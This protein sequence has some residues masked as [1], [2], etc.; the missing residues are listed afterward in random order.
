MIL[1]FRSAQALV[2]GI[3]L[4]VYKPERSVRYIFHQ[5]HEGVVHRRIYALVSFQRLFDVDNEGFADDLAYTERDNPAV[6]KY[7]RGVQAERFVNV[8]K[9]FR[10]FELDLFQ[11][12]LVG[13]LL[14]VLT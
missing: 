14:F 9:L 8:E 12:Q 2:S 3:V 7:T 1:H 5:S 11:A 10:L 6:K 4:A 13:M